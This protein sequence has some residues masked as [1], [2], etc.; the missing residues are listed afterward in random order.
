MNKLLFS[1]LAAT[2]AGVAGAGSRADD[3]DG[4]GWTPLFNGRDLTG[5]KVQF[6]D[7]D[8]GADPAR[9]FT[10]KD[11]A[12]IVGGKPKGYV[13]TDKSYT[14]YVLTYDWRF[15]EGSP[16]ESNSGCLVH[17]QP[18]H[19]VMPKSVEPQGR[20]KDHGKIF[21]I[22]FKGEAT[23]DADAHKKALRP[24]GRW[25]TTE[26][27]CGADG[28]VSV[29]LNGVPVSGCKTELTS[30]PIGFQCEGS[31]VHFKEIKIKSLK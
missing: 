2:L 19:K 13:Y 16:P 24:M 1:L 17:I 12:L 10:V 31:E 20:Y 4:D 3:N 6:E 15:P 8:K 23:F 18:P 9:T 22:G 26:V 28:S 7:K 21:F 30:G 14:N 27:T 29:K 25:S 5:W 11:G